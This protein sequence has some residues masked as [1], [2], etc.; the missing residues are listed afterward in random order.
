MVVIRFVHMK[1]PTVSLALEM[2]QRRVSTYSSGHLT[3]VCDVNG[4]NTD[5]LPRGVV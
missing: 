5:V 3:S 1:A 2:Y 4:H